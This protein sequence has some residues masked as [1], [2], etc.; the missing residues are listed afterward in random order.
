MP[1]RLIHTA[2]I[3]SIMLFVYCAAEVAFIWNSLQMLSFLNLVET[4]SDQAAID[5]QAERIDGI[6]IFVGG[7][8]IFA[9][10]ASFVSGG[11]WIYRACANSLAVRPNPE[12]ITPG[13][14]V[15]WF[16]VPFA[17]LWMPFK[18]MRQTWNGLHGNP[19]LDGPVPVWMRAWWGFWLLGNMVSILANRI[20]LD[21]VTLND[22]RTGS[23]L[24]LVSSVLSIGA[25]LLFRHLIVTLT[26]VSA[27]AQ[28][29]DEV[30][31]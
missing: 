9:V 1:Y 30:F 13:W 25:A 31:A 21:A 3:A 24:D 14:A 26:R 28:K 2:R 5:A 29:M 17:N 4:S 7:F 8:F 16:A 11:M 15:G 23:S 6:A 22:Y 12:A 27:E 20:N 19:D 18:A 10:V